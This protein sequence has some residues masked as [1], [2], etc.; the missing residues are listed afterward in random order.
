MFKC[1]NTFISPFKFL[2][3]LCFT[4]KL[5]QSEDGL[6]MSASQVILMLTSTF[7][8]DGL[9]VEQTT[10]FSINR[11]T[12]SLGNKNICFHTLLVS[13][14]VISIIQDAKSYYIQR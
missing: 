12:Q 9:M 8:Q 10:E 2:S 11:K 4:S 7:L 13:T 6:H 1:R 3:S 14:F 5:H